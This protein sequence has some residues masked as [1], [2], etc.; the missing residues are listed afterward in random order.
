M[1]HLPGKGHLSGDLQLHPLSRVWG[2]GSSFLRMALL[3]LSIDNSLL[4]VG[5]TGIADFVSVSVED[6]M[7]GVIFGKFFMNLL[8]D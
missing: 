2:W 6:F 3:C 7:Q 4:D 1:R 8:L 5:H